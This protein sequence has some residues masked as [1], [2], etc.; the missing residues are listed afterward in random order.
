MYEVIGTRASRALRVLWML[1]E[2]D[3]PYAH[4]PAS[5]RSDDARAANPLGKV[6]ALR[7]GADVIT[8]STAIMTYLADKHGGL[9]HPVGTL[10][11]ARQDAL[12]HRILDEVDAVLWMAARHSFVLPE[13]QRVPGVKDSLKWEYARNVERIADALAGPFL[14]GDAMTIP[15]ILLTHCLRWAEIAGFPKPGA[16]LIVYA[17]RLQARPAH[18]AAMALP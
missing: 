4:I 14:M 16:A 2:L 13:A 15:D 3:Q 17:D 6:P 10:E 12:T 11:R 1:E 7:V 5:P 9:T 8:D 18:R